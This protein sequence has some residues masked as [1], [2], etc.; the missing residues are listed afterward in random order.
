MEQGE[1]ASVGQ[2]NLHKTQDIIVVPIEGIS[3][4]TR[5]VLGVF[6]FLTL[7]QGRFCYSLMIYHLKLSEVM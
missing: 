4:D 3:E 7:F 6:L 5:A 1:C 2:Q